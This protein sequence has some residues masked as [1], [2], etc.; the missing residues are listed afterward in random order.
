MHLALARALQEER[1]DGSKPAAM[2]VSHNVFCFTDFA[3]VSAGW[4][5]FV[6][7]T[8]H[9]A[10]AGILNSDIDKLH[11]SKA[12]KWIEVDSLDAENW[13]QSAGRGR[14]HVDHSIL[15]HLPEKFW[16]AKKEFGGSLNATVLMR[17]IDFDHQPAPASDLLQRSLSLLFTLVLGGGFVGAWLV[18]IDSLAILKNF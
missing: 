2:D 6:N 8:T 18:V 14:Q 3:H 13:V 4:A 12:T 10:M 15:Q 5:L 16:L 17:M 11:V 7:L 9:R 1:E